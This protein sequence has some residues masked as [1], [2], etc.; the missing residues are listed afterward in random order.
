[1]CMYRMRATKREWY[2]MHIRPD[3]NVIIRP[4]HNQGC[5]EPTGTTSFVTSQSRMRSNGQNI[6]WRRQNTLMTGATTFPLR[7]IGIC[8]FSSCNLVLNLMLIAIPIVMMV[9]MNPSSR[10]VDTELPGCERNLSKQ[11]QKF[12]DMSISFRRFYV[13]QTLMAIIFNGSFWIVEYK[14]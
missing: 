8:L 7:P 3:F 2:A 13:W 11:R 1:M 6:I 5:I 4:L 14:C 12:S 10:I 9:S